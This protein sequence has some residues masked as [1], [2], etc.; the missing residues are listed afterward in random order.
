MIEC[1]NC[2]EETPEAFNFCQHCRHKIRD[3][4]GIRIGA[5]VSTRFREKRDY[6]FETGDPAVFAKPGALDYDPRLP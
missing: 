1:S 2:H 5:G 4:R 3:L 6:F